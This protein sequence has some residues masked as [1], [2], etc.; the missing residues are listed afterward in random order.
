M[1][2][3]LEEINTITALN[4]S[5]RDIDLVKPLMNDADGLTPY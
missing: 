1:R 3:C 5:S 2:K 4:R